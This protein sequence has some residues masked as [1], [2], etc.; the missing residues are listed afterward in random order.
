MTG[1]DTPASTQGQKLSILFARASS[2]AHALP[3]AANR[4]DARWDGFPGCAVD[5]GVS[6]VGSSEGDKVG[7][8]KERR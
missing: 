1:N 4:A 6:P 7:E 5:P 2:I 3:G 8:E